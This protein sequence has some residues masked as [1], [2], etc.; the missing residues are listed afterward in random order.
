MESI[1]EKEV[2]DALTN[3]S[4]SEDLLIKAIA[5]SGNEEIQKAMLTYQSNKNKFYSLKMKSMIES[6]KRLLIK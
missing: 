2:S 1:S 5:D 6:L 3:M 4:V